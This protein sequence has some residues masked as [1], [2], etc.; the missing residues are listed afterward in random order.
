MCLKKSKLKELMEDYPDARRFYMSRAWHRRIELRR[1]MKKH[2]QKLQNHSSLKTKK[3]KQTDKS[4]KEKADKEN[5]LNDVGLDDKGN[6]DSENESHSSFEDSEDYG[7]EDQEESE[8]EEFSG[9]NTDSDEIAKNK[10]KKKKRE[11][12][13]KYKS[14]FFFDV[15]PIK[16]LTNDIEI[17]ELERISADEQ[18]ENREDILKERNKKKSQQNAENIQQ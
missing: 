17:E 3:P 11:M 4:D 10:N 2:Q 8:L 13:N 16:E 6:E 18:T 15:E 7:S 14:K 5:G 9:S 12:N 1:R